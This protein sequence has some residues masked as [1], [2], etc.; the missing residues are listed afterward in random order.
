MCI[1]AYINTYIYIVYTPS[2][3]E[4]PICFDFMFIVYRQ[5]KTSKLR[6]PKKHPKISN[7]DLRSLFRSLLAPIWHQFDVYLMTP[8]KLCFATRIMRNACFYFRN[9]FILGL[10]FDQN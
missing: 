9:P 2:G 1:H 4:F 7:N 3:L 10:N 8:R 6:L 5:K